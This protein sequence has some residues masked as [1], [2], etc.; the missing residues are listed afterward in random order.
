M[1]ALASRTNV[2]FF[3][4]LCRELSSSDTSATAREDLPGENLHFPFL[5]PKLKET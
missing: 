2:T 4:V 3:R 5:Y 1:S